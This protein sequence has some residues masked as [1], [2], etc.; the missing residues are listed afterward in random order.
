ML[1]CKIAFWGKSMLGGG[2]TTSTALKVLGDAVDRRASA[3][4]K[5]KVSIPTKANCSMYAYEVLA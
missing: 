4:A 5:R 1:P 2:N 3:E